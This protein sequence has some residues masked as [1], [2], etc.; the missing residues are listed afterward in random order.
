MMTKVT[1]LG[2]SASSLTGAFCAVNKDYSLAS[3]NAMA[4]MGIAGEI[5]Y[6]NSNGPGSLQTN[7]LD[8]LYNISKEEIQ[9]RLKLRK[10]E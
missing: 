8:A 1:G 6:E 10:E 2:C 7:F 9:T 5:A 4:I 3:A